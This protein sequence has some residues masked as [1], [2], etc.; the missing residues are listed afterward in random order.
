MLF[1]SFRSLRGIQGEARDGRVF[2][3]KLE[4]IFGKAGKGRKERLTT[5]IKDLDELTPENRLI[6]LAKLEKAGLWEKWRFIAKNGM[7]AGTRTQEKNILSNQLWFAMQEAERVY[8]A[9]A[10]VVVAGVARRPRERFFRESLEAMFAYPQGY[11]QGFS[12]FFRKFRNGINKG[13][14]SKF[15]LISRD[16]RVYINPL[17][18]GKGARAVEVPVRMLD[19]ADSAQKELITETDRK[20]V[21]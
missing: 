13:T 4:G 11:K 20:S 17:G 14:A 10:E 21:V 19:A 8:G 7:L 18:S 6:A 5:L 16:Q 2:M 3:K 1:R 15:D 12:V 9:A